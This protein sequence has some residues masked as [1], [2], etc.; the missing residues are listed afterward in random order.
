V[1]TAHHLRHQAVAVLYRG[2]DIGSSASTKAADER[3]IFSGL[4]LHVDLS[5]YESRQADGALAP[6]QEAAPHSIPAACNSKA[7]AHSS[8]DCGMS[9][10]ASTGNLAKQVQAITGQLRANLNA[11]QGMIDEFE[12]VGR[13]I[14]DLQSAVSALESKAGHVLQAIESLRAGGAASVVMLPS[15]VHSKVTICYDVMQSTGRN[16]R[17][18][19][20]TT[21]PCIA[22]FQNGTLA[23]A[24]PPSRTVHLCKK[25]SAADTSGA[26]FCKDKVHVTMRKPSGP[27]VFV[28]QFYS[29]A[30]DGNVLYVIGTPSSGVCCIW[31][32]SFTTG[33]PE[34]S[35]EYRYTCVTPPYGFAV[36]T[37][38]SGSRGALHVARTGNGFSLKLDKV[39]ASDKLFVVSEYADVAVAVDPDG[40]VA[41]VDRQRSRLHVQ[42]WP[43]DAA[44]A[45]DAVVPTDTARVISLPARPDGITFDSMG[46]LVVV[47]SS[48]STVYWIDYAGGSVHAS[49][50]CTPSLTGSV[51]VDD[52]GRLL[53]AVNGGV[54]CV[55]P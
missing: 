7:P 16:A 4:A 52:A 8:G 44:A 55:A 5:P 50:V 40:N 34:L 41:I 48:T 36:T 28:P 17:K 25:Q 51:A 2:M 23:I 21:A 33:K 31:S 14:G 37:T 32:A 6:Q 47:C 22:V 18:F 35:E 38:N 46:R 24:E 30:S 13:R 20:Y 49:A 27:A 29:I 1:H 9:A 53:A 45:A 3:H 15:V 42:R 43:S 11:V 54:V 12:A 19:I 39:E 26:L 10:Q